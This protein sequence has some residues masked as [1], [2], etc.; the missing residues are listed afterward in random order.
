ML[1]W[2]TLN[3]Q[4]RAEDGFE[5]ILQLFVRVGDQVL[6][7]EPRTSCMINTLKLY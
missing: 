1:C 7:I 5:L 3:L 2:L 6:E 4:C